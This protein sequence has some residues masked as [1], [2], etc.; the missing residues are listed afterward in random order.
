M[1]GDYF[2]PD[3]YRTRRKHQFLYRK[4]GNETVLI[5]YSE[6][7]INTVSLGQEV[8]TIQVFANVMIDGVL[9]NVPIALDV[10][11]YDRDMIWAAYH[12]S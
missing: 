7:G 8:N 10:T 12:V 5:L 9:M 6:Y 3:S 1:Y 4:K 2:L 11:E